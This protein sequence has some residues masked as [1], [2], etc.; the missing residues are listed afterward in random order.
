[1]SN[2]TLFIRERYS[3]FVV[4]NQTRQDHL[5]QDITLSAGVQ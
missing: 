3:V 4:S 5:K 2:S 1:M